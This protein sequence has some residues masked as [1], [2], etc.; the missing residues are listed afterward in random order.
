MADGE[1]R[2]HRKVHLQRHQAPVSYLCGDMESDDS[3]ESQKVVAK[4]SKALQATDEVAD[5]VEHPPHEPE[6]HGIHLA[7]DDKRSYYLWYLHQLGVGMFV[8]VTLI[9]I[10]GQ[11]MRVH[12]DAWISV[13]AKRLYAPQCYTSDAFYAGLYSIHDSHSGFPY[14]CID[15]CIRLVLHRR[16]LCQQ[17][18]QLLLHRC[19][20]G[21]R[22]LLSRHSDWRV[23]RVLL[24]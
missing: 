24:A 19:C 4:P 8:A 15:V 21:S 13:W 9:F 7:D 23:A 10:V 3:A 5:K 18:S 16:N 22:A 14:T 2:I 17:D 1:D 11:I 20:L 6:E 12:S